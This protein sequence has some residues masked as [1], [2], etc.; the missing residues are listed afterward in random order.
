MQH[1]L[2]S[3]HR[4]GPHC[5]STPFSTDSRSDRSA[6]AAV[7]MPPAHSCHEAVHLRRFMLL[8]LSLV[9][10][11]LLVMAD[12]EVSGLQG[13]LCSA[14][15]MLPYLKRSACIEASISSSQ[16]ASSTSAPSGMLQAPLT[17]PFATTL[18]S[19]SMHPGL[20]CNRQLQ[21]L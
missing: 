11:G 15:C 19:C 18:P 2:I 13:A 20:F 6:C 12:L 4:H 10:E 7:A 9:P 16:P 17:L 14:L 21:F 5:I 3:Q 1:W 8:H